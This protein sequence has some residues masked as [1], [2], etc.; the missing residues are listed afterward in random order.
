MDLKDLSI[1]ENLYTT[2]CISKTSENLYLTQPAVT[3]R[4]KKI[5]REFSVKI[6]NRHPNGI[7]FTEEGKLILE[8]AQ[9][10]LKAYDD[11]KFELKT[12]NNS[13]YGNINICVGSTFAKYFLAQLIK[14]FKNIYPNISINIFTIASRY[15]TTEKLQENDIDISLMR[16]T[17]SKIY[18]ENDILFKEPYGI[19]SSKPI[20]DFFKLKETNLISYNYTDINFF[21]SWWENKFGESYSGPIV[22]VDSSEAIISLISQDLGWSIL[23]MVHI[24]HHK[25]LYFYPMLNDNNTIRSLKNVLVR[26]KDS[27]NEIVELFVEFLKTNAK[28][29]SI[30]LFNS[31]IKSNIVCEPEE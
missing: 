10:F 15:A 25:S 30:Q 26:N 8:F 6:L 13:V 28:L 5:E 14:D 21:K 19:I 31:A 29:H 9:K 11:L 2:K 18:G 17:D 1:L 23:P 7:T 24:S 22:T 27:K 16:T 3:L 4:I 12:V 20:T